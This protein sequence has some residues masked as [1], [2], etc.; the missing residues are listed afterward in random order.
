M[1]LPRRQI[2]LS[3]DQIREPDLH[4]GDIYRLLPGDPKMTR[5][6]ALLSVQFSQPRAASLLSSGRI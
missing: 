1:G 5:C 2:P 4:T 3:Q 6:G